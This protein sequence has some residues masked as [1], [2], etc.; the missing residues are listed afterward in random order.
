MISDTEKQ[1]LASLFLDRY[2]DDVQEAPTFHVIAGG[3]G[4]GKT[5][6]RK[7]KLSEGVLPAETYLHDP[8][9]VMLSLHGYQADMAEHNDAAIAFDKW[10]LTARTEAENMLDT[11]LKHRLNIIYE[12]TCGMPEVRDFLSTVKDS[13][14]QLIM[15]VIHTDIDIAKQRAIAR[16]AVEGRHIP[17]AIITERHH[18]LKS[19]WKDYCDI[20]DQINLYNNSGDQAQFTHVFE[21][22]NNAPTIH[23][24]ELYDLFLKIPDAA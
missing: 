23:A 5:S 21:G 8:D 10:E 4:S 19:L 9:D 1:R 16:E 20:A 24:P 12:R 6:F 7:K 14:Y 11:A 3:V 18:M 15:H 13:G 17:P 2:L 22:R